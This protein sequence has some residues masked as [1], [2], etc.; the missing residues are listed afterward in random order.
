MVLANKTD[1]LSLLTRVCMVE[2]ASFL[3]CMCTL[4]LCPHM[5]A[6]FFRWSIASPEFYLQHQEEPGVMLHTCHCSI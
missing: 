2:K 3:S 6:S 1:D 5:K 4:W